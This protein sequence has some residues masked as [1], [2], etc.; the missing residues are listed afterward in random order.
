MAG[1]LATNVAV[2]PSAELYDP[3]TGTFAQ[4]GS[5]TTARVG[6]TATLLGNGKILI[7]GG[8]VLTAELFDP[9]TGTF[10]KTGSMTTARDSHT[11]TLLNDGTVLVTGGEYLTSV[12]PFP[13]KL[14][15]S[16][17]SAELYDPT[18]GTFGYT[19]NMAAQRVFHTATLLTNGDVLVT[20]GTQL[21]SV[22][23]GLP[24]DN[25]PS[26]KSL[27]IASAERFH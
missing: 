6:H 10:T 3:A 1:A 18:N 22:P 8:G 25:C 7:A 14:K 16:S 5:M 21:T 15:F 4:T 24:P 13:C 19:G 23:G 2:W 26:N 17:A 11:A 27:V 9:T 12:F 20:G